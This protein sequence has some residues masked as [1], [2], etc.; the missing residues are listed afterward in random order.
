MTGQYRYLSSTISRVLHFGALER[1]YSISWTM[2]KRFLGQGM[3]LWEQNVII[4]IT[5]LPRWEGKMVDNCFHCFF[6]RWRTNHDVSFKRMRLLECI[7][8]E[9]IN[10]HYTFEKTEP[11]TVCIFGLFACHNFTCTHLRGP[12]LNWNHRNV[13]CTLIICVMHRV[14][15]IRDHGNLVSLFIFYYFY[16]FSIILY[17]FRA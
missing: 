6:G 10:H 13:D 17:H 14:S 16:V 11:K 15:V 2:K 8:I 7:D 9:C 1:K 3:I 12:G 5:W 4:Y